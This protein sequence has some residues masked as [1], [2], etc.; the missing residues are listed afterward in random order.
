MKIMKKY[1]LFSALLFAMGSCA[2]IHTTQHDPL[3]PGQAKKV[4]GDQS[5]RE[6]APGQQNKNKNKNKSNEDPSLFG[7]F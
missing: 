1:L 2:T 6:Y 7:I 4:H 5:A 3:P